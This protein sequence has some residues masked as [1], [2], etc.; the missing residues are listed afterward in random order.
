MQGQQAVHV[1]GPNMTTDENKA[2]A[3]RFIEEVANRGNFAVIDELIAPDFEVR[4]AVIPV[5]T[6]P[7]GVKQVFGAVR[8]AFPDFHETIE[9][10]LADEDRVMVRWST[11]GTHR[12]EFAGIPATGKE[13]TWRGVFILRV[14]GGRFVEMWQ[15][16]DQLGL[17]QQLGATVTMPAASPA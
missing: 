16:H 14:A 8:D 1:E 7:E 5:S 15:L 11:R 9:D 13:V 2:M 12:G 17:L 3:R 4:D 10:V 6:G